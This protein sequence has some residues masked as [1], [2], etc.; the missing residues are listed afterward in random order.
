LR[1]W[2]GDFTQGRKDAKIFGNISK[3]RGVPAF[4]HT[5]AL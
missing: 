1:E 2:S 3:L 4:D 5:G